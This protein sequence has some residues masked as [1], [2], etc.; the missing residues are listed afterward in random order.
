V[1]R[2]G[3]ENEKGQ[4]INPVD[5]NS[6]EYYE[7]ENINKDDRELVKP[8]VI[9]VFEDGQE[10]N[11]EEY[12]KDTLQ[13]LSKRHYFCINGDNPLRG[14]FILDSD[15]NNMNIALYFEYEP[16][17]V[18]LNFLEKGTNKSL[19]NSKIY[20]Y[21]GGESFNLKETNPKKIKGYEFV[22]M[23]GQL[24]GTFEG[25]P[26]ERVDNEVAKQISKVINVYYKPVEQIKDYKVE[27]N[28]YEELTGKKLAEST[29]DI[30]LNNE[31]I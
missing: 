12:A 6:T 11:L 7:A 18:T 2:E 27:F 13:E 15:D 29:E 31:D 17:T 8:I 23:T 30:V 21:K 10:F 3:G 9:S 5:T 25:T 19:A 24:V 1:S 4:Y 20:N 16:Y 26:E 28:Y 14:I 22:E